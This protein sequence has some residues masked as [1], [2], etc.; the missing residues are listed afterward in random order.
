MKHMKILCPSKS[1]SPLLNT[2]ELGELNDQ[3]INAVFLPLPPNDAQRIGEKALE[4]KKP[5]SLLLKQ[6][7][8]S[9]LSLQERKDFHLAEEKFHLGELEKLPPE[10]YRNDPY[11]KALSA[12]EKKRLG[13]FCLKVR[14]LH[15]YVPF[16][17]A[18]KRVD[19]KS[20]FKDTTPLGYFTEPFPT[21]ALEENGRVWMSLV[22]HEIETM[23]EDIQKAKGDVVVMGCGLGYFAYSISLKKE[24]TSIR[25]VERSEKVL[26]L[27]SRYLLP[28]FPYPEKIMLIQ[29]DALEVASEKEFNCD[30][31]Y[32][33]LWHDCEDG[34]PLYLSFKKREK[35]GITYAYWIE[36]DM[37]VYFRRHLNALLEEEIQG[38]EDKDYLHEENFSDHLINRLHFLLKSHR[39]SSIDDALELYRDPSLKHLAKALGE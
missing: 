29:R 19:P 10:P 17:Y 4:T 3:I 15:P 9:S 38:S 28:L 20:Y 26:A 33:D 5:Y 2:V 25:I 7:I 16:C 37:L 6:Q 36:K 34:L 24:V 22:P 31:C 14:T 32:V 13:S 21:Y 30:F 1:L 18:S 35:E 27:F 39:I 8:T 11:Q 12:L 23:K